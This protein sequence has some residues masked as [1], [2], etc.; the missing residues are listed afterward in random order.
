MYIYKFLLNNQVVYVGKTND[1]S[2]RVSQHRTENRITKWDDIEFLVVEDNLANDLEGYLIYKYSPVFNKVYPRFYQTFD[3]R[4]LKWVNY[5][6]YCGHLHPITSENTNR[7]IDGS[8]YSLTLYKYLKKH[9]NSGSD[10]TI[11]VMDL[12]K[13]LG[14]IGRDRVFI[15]EKDKYYNFKDFKKRVLIPAIREIN[16]YTDMTVTIADYIFIGRKIIQI[17]FHLS[18]DR[19]EHN[20]LP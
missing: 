2:H 12:R 4:K 11:D 7:K 16:E 15:T 5:F 13:E 10:I 17:V 3:L 19:G 1:I 18:K 6:S 20:T 9:S 8:K 14:L